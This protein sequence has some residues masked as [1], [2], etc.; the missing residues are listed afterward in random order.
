MNIIVIPEGIRK[1]RTTSFSHRQLL[2]LLLVGGMLLPTLFGVIAF[3]IQD[4]IARSANP[5]DQITAYAKELAQ[6]ARMLDAAKRDAT[7]NLNA[8]TRHMGQLQA[9]IL[10]LNALGGRLTHMAGLDHRE[11]NF[12]ADVAQG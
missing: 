12:D 2:V 9:Q 8:L 6:Q 1:G 5:E 3:R 4:M 10:R 11:F 7:M